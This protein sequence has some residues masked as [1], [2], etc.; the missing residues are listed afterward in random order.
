MTIHSSEHPISHFS[1]RSNG[2][3]AKFVAYTPPFGRYLGTYMA[4]EGNYYEPD[5]YVEFCNNMDEYE[6]F[7]A[8][9]KVM[10][11]LHQRFWSRDDRIVER[12]KALLFERSQMGMAGRRGLT[13]THYDVRG[14][15]RYSFGLI[16]I[17]PQNQYDRTFIGYT[18]LYQSRTAGR[19]TTFYE[20]IPRIPDALLGCEMSSHS[21]GGS[22]YAESVFIPDIDIRKLDARNINERGIDITSLQGGDLLMQYVSGIIVLKRKPDADAFNW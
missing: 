20:S 1:I 18:R 9:E 17:S 5:I 12:T 16:Y 14:L 22:S 15:R 3:N 11:Q 6:R 7:R 2:E 10:Y 8:Y 19:P 13:V 4:P 21:P